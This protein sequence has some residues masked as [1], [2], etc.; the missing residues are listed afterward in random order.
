VTETQVT[1]RFTVPSS[2]L[3]WAP[4]A[5]GRLHTTVSVA[6]ADQDKRGGWQE[7]VAHVYSFG[8]PAGVAPAADRATQISFEM[9]YHESHHVR[10]VVRDD[11]S[12]RVGSSEITLDTPKRLAPKPPG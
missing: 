12:A 7:Q 1:V 8:L 11:A 2:S 4:D 9:P 5:Q 3:S 10:F 6:A